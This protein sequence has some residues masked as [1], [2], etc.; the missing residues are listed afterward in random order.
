MCPLRL[1]R[2]DSKHIV[3]IFKCTSFQKHLGLFLDDKLN[4][5]SHS[6]EKMKK[7]D[8]GI[9]VL[10]K[11]QHILPRKTILRIHKSFIWPHLDYR[12]IINDQLNDKNFSKKIES[13]QYNKA[14]AITGAFDLS[15][16]YVHSMFTLL[17]IKQIFGKIKSLREASKSVTQLWSRM[18]P[19]GLFYRFYYQIG[20]IIMKLSKA[21]LS[22][23]WIWTTISGKWYLLVNGSC[24]LV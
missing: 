10:K 6:K 24:C 17:L 23:G 3:K 8:K 14:L 15:Y 22:E 21:G 5:N 2:F 9:D 19:D 1:S 11:L 20:E 7:L 16:H 18:I 13:Y 4:F 12:D